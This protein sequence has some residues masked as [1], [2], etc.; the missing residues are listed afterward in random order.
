LLPVRAL[1]WAVAGCAVAGSATGQEAPSAAT[2]TIGSPAPALDIE[3]WLSDGGG[4]FP[5][6]TEFAPGKVYV[7]EFWATW[8][9][10][11]VASMPH[12]AETQ[13]TYAEKGVQIVSVS[14]EPLETVTMFLG[15]PVRGAEG[16]AAGDGSSEEA[17]TYAQLTSAYCL[18]TDPDESVKKA[19]MDAAA[20]GGIPTAFLVGKTGQIEWIGHPMAMDEPLAQVVADAW[21]RDAFAAEFVRSQQRDRLRMELMQIVGLAL[22]E[23]NP[24]MEKVKAALLEARRQAGD[25]EELLTWLNTLEMRVLT[26][27]AMTLDLNGR[28]EEADAEWAKAFSQLQGQAGRLARAQR[29]TALLRAGEHVRSVATLAELTGDA[30]AEPQLLNA[31]A[32]QIYELASQGPQLAPELVSSAL[33][34]AE[35]AARAAPDDASTLDTLAHLLHLSGQLDRAVEVQ[36]KAAASAGPAAADIQAFLD[37][38]RSEQQNP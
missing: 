6:V 26:Q 36:Q 14:D 21:D 7:V 32:W 15:K 3:H 38:L 12:L 11:C 20:Q 22:R 24:D 4:K 33:D 37:Q 31:L 16:S 13:A 28:H 10:Q 8:C 19:Y 30:E 5:K 18:T 35:T 29:L 9:G 2:L 23:E 27:P 1:A 34:A 17:T 25:D